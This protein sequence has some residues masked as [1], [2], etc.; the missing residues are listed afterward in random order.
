[1][2]TRQECI[3]AAGAIYGGILA[4]PERAAALRD[5]RARHI[6]TADPTNVPDKAPTVGSGDSPSLPGSPRQ[7]RASNARRTSA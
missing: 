6:H 7:G 3:A 2:T 5:H 1:M 4:D